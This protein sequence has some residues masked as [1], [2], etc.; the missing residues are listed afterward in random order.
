MA[1]LTGGDVSALLTAK[2][3]KMRY[4]GLS[5]SQM[6]ARMSSKG[7]QKREASSG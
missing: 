1:W 2:S 6:D 7:I 4:L 5:Y 3:M